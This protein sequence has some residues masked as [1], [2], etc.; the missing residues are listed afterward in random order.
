STPSSPSAPSAPSAPSNLYK[1]GDL[2]R[3]LPD[4][5]LEYLGRIDYQVK[6]RGFRIELGE[7]ESILMEYPGIK[8]AVVTLYKN[9]DDEKLIAYLVTSSEISQSN[10]QQFLQGKLPAYMIPSNYMML[11][12]FPLTPN[13]KIDRKA[14]PIPDN[15]R[16]ELDNFVIPKTKIEQEIAQIW[17]EV[18]QIDKIGIHDNFFDLGGHSL[19]M[20]KVHSKLREKFSHDVSLVEMFRY[21]TISALVT[22]FSDASNKQHS[23]NSSSRNEQFSTGKERLK[24]RLKKR[25]G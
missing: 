23:D 9:H 3:Y 2:V 16:P 12:E 6:L 10:L 5:N 13:R 15:I 21:P 14:L 20:V 19:L 7:I 25:K 18:L 11:E 4:G 22:Y 8:Q 17:Q 1:T 24:Q